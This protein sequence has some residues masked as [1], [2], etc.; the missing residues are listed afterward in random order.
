M[1]HTL[2]FSLL[3]ILLPGCAS[4]FSGDDNADPPAEL[5]KLTPE[6]TLKKLWGT[7][8]GVG[9]DE[10]LVNLVPV[11]Y[12][13]QILA[14][15]RKGTVE[16][17]DLYT[18]KRVWKTVTRKPIS[19]GPGVGEGL[20]LVGTSEAEVLALSDETGEVVWEAMVT[21]EVLSIPRI[22]SGI[23]VVQTIDGNVSALD[24]DDGS[25]IWTY[26]RTVPVLTLRGSS[27]PAVERGLVVAGFA[28]GK[29]AAIALENGRVLWETS[30]ADPRGRSELE[31][32]VDLDSDPLIDGNIVYVTTY[33]GRVASVDITSGR[34]VWARD[35]SSHKGVDVDYN[36]IYL[37]DDGS[38]VWALSSANGASVWKQ[39]KVHG[40]ALTTPVWFGDYVVVG[41]FEGYLH[42]LSRLDGRLLARTRL[43]KAGIM[44]KPV[45]A[46][47]NF[48]VFGMGGRLAAYTVE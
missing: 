29:L 2:L 46:G 32:M 11:F 3:V 12:G 17:L 31:R 14:A 27:S 20:V 30:I 15:D 10:Q 23:V 42:I 47:D 25:R 4:M 13:D 8:V 34:M 6:V 16:A 9:A 22:D 5:E 41:D 44:A 1:R 40:R 18:G 7:K 43:D 21:S 48:Y 36:Q 45:Q 39:D 19:A 26:D 33:H 38:N 35:I 37:V 24:A 28:S